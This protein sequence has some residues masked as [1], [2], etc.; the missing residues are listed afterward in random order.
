MN[1]TL[2]LEFHSPSDGGSYSILNFSYVLSY[3]PF[4]LPF[5]V[6]PKI[7]NKLVLLV[8]SLNG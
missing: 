3:N 1:R 4:T 5:N 6:T 8:P 7:Q 2:I